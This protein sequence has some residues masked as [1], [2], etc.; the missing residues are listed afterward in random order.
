MIDILVPML[1]RTHNIEPLLES[2]VTNTAG[3]W[4]F[5]FV[6]SPKDEG[7]IEA[8]R[9]TAQETLIVDWPPRAADYA[10][11][12]AYG[13]ERTDSEWVFQ[14]ADDIRFHPGWD[15]Q[16]LA[17]AKQRSVVGTNDLHHPGARRGTHSTHMLFRRSYISEQGGTF[18][19]SGVI[20]SEAYDH[21]YVDNEFILT[22][23]RRGEWVFAKHS[24]VEH[25]HPNWGNAEEDETYRKSVRQAARDH[26]IFQ[27]RAKRLNRAFRKQ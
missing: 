8:C 27:A 13:F 10:K 26:R 11:K 20:F 23:R 15:T 24:V 1:G 14:G 12:L 25:F 21:S 5:V 22:A 4:R 7:V 2:V 18:D 17:A 9:S 3:P 6:C 19:G 16:A